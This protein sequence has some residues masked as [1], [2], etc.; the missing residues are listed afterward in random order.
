MKH[1][2]NVTITI[3]I[4]FF[5]TQLFGLFLV[6]EDISSITYINDT[7]V[8]E[9]GDT[10]LGQR[11]E[12]SGA[13]SFFFIAIS[14]L[15]GTLL[16]LGIIKYGKV[17]LWK[18][19]FFLAIFFAISLALGVVMNYL[20]A[21]L[22]ALALTILKLWKRNAITHNLSEV[23]MYSGIAVLIVPMFDLLWGF[24]LLFAISIYDIYAVWKSKH[25]VKMAKFQSEN[26]MFAGLMIPYDNKH[27]KLRL[28]QDPKLESKTISKKKK[29]TQNAILGGGDVAFPLIFSGVVMEHLIING[30]SRTAAFLQASIIAFCVT[31]AISGLFFFAK[32]D[33]FYPAMPFVTFGCVIGYL[34]I[35][36]I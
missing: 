3:I 17:K 18:A 33:K 31:L 26:K 22:I 12:T 13:E 10:S 2:L 5:I 21:Y 9:H 16:V 15:V 19:W 7:I 1:K 20:I 34:I 36:L 8:V 28:P 23:L 32:K 4:I 6:Q 35:L 30:L 14:V 25:M 29:T 27:M 11:P 24:I